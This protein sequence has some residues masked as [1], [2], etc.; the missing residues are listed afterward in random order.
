MTK[1]APQIPNLNRAVFTSGYKPL[2]LAIK[3]NRG[4][5][6]G[7]ALQRYELMDIRVTWL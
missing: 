1:Y 2:A 6:Q 3:G 7:V 4:D 5:I